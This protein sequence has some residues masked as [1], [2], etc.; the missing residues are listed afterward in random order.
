MPDPTAPVAPPRPAYVG[1]VPRGCRSAEQPPA[2]AA[3]AAAQPGIATPLTRHNAVRAAPRR[4]RSTRASRAPPT[5][6]GSAYVTAHLA[7]LARAD[8]AKPQPAGGR[9][10]GRA[11]AL[12]PHRRREPAACEAEPTSG[13]ARSELPGAPA[14]AP[15]KPPA[16]RASTPAPRWPASERREVAPGSHARARAGVARSLQRCGISEELADE[17]IDG[18]S[19]HALALAP[20]AGLAQA[21]RATLAQRIPVA[22][23]L[24]SK[25]AAIVIVGAG[26]AGKTTCCATLLGAYRKSS[27]LSAS[28][29]TITREAPSAASCR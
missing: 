11:A 3:Y 10:R 6:A 22:P 14:P 5:R 20:R 8:R 21:V 19:A 29:A 7:A 27:S 1:A 9:A 16:E 15:F 17:L 18:A 26:G 23:P 24:P 4:R 2:A 28:F 25:G 12:A 13:S